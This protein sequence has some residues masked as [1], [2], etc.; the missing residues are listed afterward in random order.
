[1]RTSGEPRYNV[2]CDAGEEFDINDYWLHDGEDRDGWY[3]IGR[4]S[5][6]LPYMCHCNIML[7]QKLTSSCIE[8][9]QQIS[10]LLTAIAGCFR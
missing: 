1:M 3:A 6:P 8:L 9:H 5:L 10:A 2:L 4:P 7:C